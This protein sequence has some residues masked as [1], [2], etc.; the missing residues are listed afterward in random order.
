MSI[1]DDRVEW[2]YYE[3]IEDPV[4]EKGALASSEGFCQLKQKCN[5][6][7]GKPLNEGL[8][9]CSVSQDEIYDDVVVYI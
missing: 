7:F 6:N 3:T 2:D 5:S 1:Y 4:V 8:Q 9:N